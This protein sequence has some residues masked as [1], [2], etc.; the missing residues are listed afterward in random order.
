MKFYIALFISKLAY[1][2]LKLLR[3]PATSFAGFVALKICPNFLKY[4][5]RYIDKAFIN[6]T[7][8]NG[9]TTT[10]GIL[11]H[12]LEENSNKVIHNIK[13]ANML[14][15]IANVFVRYI[16]P[17]KKYDYAVIETDEAYLTKVYDF[18]KGDY[19]IVTNLFC[20]QLDRYGEADFTSKI[21]Q[22]AIA[23]NSGLKLVLNAD[24]PV[25]KEFGKNKNAIYYGIKNNADYTANMT[26]Y[27]SYFELEIN[28][29]LKFKV[30]LVGEY[31]AYN[32]LAAIAAAL[33]NGFSKEQIQKALD[34]Y[35]TAFGRAE[36]RILD[37]H[38]TIIQLIKNPT[39]ANEVLKTVDLNSNIIIALNDAYAD[40][41]DISWIWDTDF[42][43]LKNISKPIIASGSRAYDIAIRLKHAGISTDKIIVEPDV[44]QA[45]KKITN[46]C[47]NDEKITILPSYTAL[48]KISKY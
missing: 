30:N 31:N 3:R 6:I 42:E 28:S 22:E 19:L 5:Q 39:A 37:G 34:S 13:G 26:M 24:D 40:G 11:A 21:I 7:G 4:T 43:K 8:T 45:I 33:E 29:S 44:K 18:V 2:G 9:K 23:K 47:E 46:E 15:G 38:K 1:I 25:V 32:A 36:T 17:I 35:H 20:D 48:L 16:C 14:S 12:I 27:D 41:R 10:S